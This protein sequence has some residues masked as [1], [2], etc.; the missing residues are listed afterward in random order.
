MSICMD[1]RTD[2][3]EASFYCPSGFRG[4]FILPLL[5][6]ARTGPAGT[7]L[8][9][10]R[11]CWPPSQPV[12]PSPVPSTH[13]TCRDSP[14]PSPPLLDTVT[15]G[16]PLSRAQHGPETRAPSRTDGR[17]EFIY[18]ILSRTLNPRNSG[19]E[20]NLRRFGFGAVS[21]WQLIVKREGGDG[22]FALFEFG[23]FA[24]ALETL[25]C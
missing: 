3:G 18:K 25:R 13:R 7:L 12:S 14:V 6:K 9:P 23:L 5:S 1:D 21:E 20:F 17:S 8:C 19:P 4:G 2:S 16:Q 15:A 22:N 11:P 10:A 24:A